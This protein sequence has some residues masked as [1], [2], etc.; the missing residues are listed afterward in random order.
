MF[1]FVNILLLLLLLRLAQP[2][3][4]GGLRVHGHLWRHAARG[5]GP[6]D[7]RVPRGGDQSAHHHGRAGARVRPRTGQNTVG[8]THQLTFELAFEP[9]PDLNL[10]PDSE[11]TF[12][13]SLGEGARRGGGRGEG[14]RPICVE[15]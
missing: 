8:F 3:E 6:S 9:T 4:C 15:H 1:N 11:L 14:E 12:E 13:R 10:G 7:Q 2:A 5:A